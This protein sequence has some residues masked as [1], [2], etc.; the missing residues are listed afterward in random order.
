MTINQKA[1]LAGLIDGDGSIMLQFKPQKRMKFLF[2]AKSTVIIYQDAKMKSEVAKLWNI[3]GA[4]YQY[5]RNDHI[6]EIRIEGFA[7]V[8]KLLSGLKPFLRFKRKQARLMIKALDILG[9]KNYSIKDFLT[10]CVI[11]DKI[12]SFNY[13]SI[14]R[15]YDSKFILSELKRQKVVPVTTGS[16]L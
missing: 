7:Q 1:Y 4:G 3:I 13:R 14:H 10:A 15:K 6:C 2:R 12:S 11:A 16:R 5:E 8:K 9:K